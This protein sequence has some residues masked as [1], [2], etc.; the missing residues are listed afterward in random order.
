MDSNLFDKKIS[1]L[2]EQNK[3]LL[4]SFANKEIVWKNIES[5]LQKPLRI[6]LFRYMAVSAAACVVLVLSFTFLFH[7]ERIN[8]N[9]VKTGQAGSKEIVREIHENEPPLVKKD[10]VFTIYEK[11]K[12]EK[13][14]KKNPVIAKETKEENLVADAFVPVA[15][16]KLPEMQENIESI[17]PQPDELQVTIPK[18]EIKVRVSLSPAKQRNEKKGKIEFKL[19]NSKLNRYENNTNYVAGTIVPFN[20]F[21]STEHIYSE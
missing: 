18:N 16:E 14:V 10:S 8:K 1:E 7:S 17:V 12:V 5:R 15:E 6:K 9:E 11:R 4:P 2:L 3:E 20:F 13:P 19:N 21:R